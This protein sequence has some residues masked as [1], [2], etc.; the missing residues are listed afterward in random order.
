MSVWFTAVCP[1]DLVFAWSACLIVRLASP[2]AY[3]LL[4]SN[5]PPGHPSHGDLQRALS[6]TSH[7]CP[8]PTT[9]MVHSTGIRARSGL[10]PLQALSKWES[11]R[12]REGRSSEAV[13]PP[14]RGS[15]PLQWCFPIIFPFWLIGAKQTRSLIAEGKWA[16]DS[17][18]PRFCLTGIPTESRSKLKSSAH[19][20][21]SGSFYC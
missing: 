14:R 9:G 18:L 15:G 2:L 3:L 10:G 5:L 16:E 1:W 8:T 6:N 20:I 13:G 17:W 12:Q 19:Q 11:Q 21:A 7:S 4:A